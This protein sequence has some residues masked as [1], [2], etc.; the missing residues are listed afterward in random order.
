VAQGRGLLGEATRAHEWW[1]RWRSV[2][3]VAE[4]GGSLSL[5]GREIELRF[6]VAARGIRWSVHVGRRRNGG[7]KWPAAGR[8]TVGGVARVGLVVAMSRALGRF[9]AEA[10]GRWASA[11]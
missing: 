5:C 4:R 6:G 11:Y 8:E 9:D 2:G 7:R 1:F 10:C 3:R